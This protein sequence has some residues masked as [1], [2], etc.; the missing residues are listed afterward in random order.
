METPCSNES[1]LFFFKRQR[2]ELH[3]KK[4]TLADRPPNG[5]REIKT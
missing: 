5:M 4:E 1:I 2:S 3:L